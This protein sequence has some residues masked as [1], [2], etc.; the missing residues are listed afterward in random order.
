V[1]TSHHGETVRCPACSHTLG[2]LNQ[3][4]LLPLQRGSTT[5]CP[6]CGR[7]L[8]WNRSSLRREHLAAT[9]VLSGVLLFFALIVEIVE[10]SATTR[11]VL[12]SVAL[13]LTFFGGSVADT[14]PAASQ[15]DLVE[16]D[17]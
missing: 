10:V 4:R 7:L 16:D 15:I 8:Q 5:R 2:R 1:G 6:A 17:T 9:L 3:R 11:L 13:I 14:S 12:F